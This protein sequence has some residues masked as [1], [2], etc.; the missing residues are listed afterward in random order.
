MSLKVGPVRD[1][2]L[3]LGGLAVLAHETFIT[4]HPREVLLIVVAAMLGIPAT[5]RTD[6]LFQRGRSG[7]EDST[8]SSEQSPPTSTP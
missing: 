3:L 1:V 8:D 2:A 7:E 4:Q 6:R 5:L